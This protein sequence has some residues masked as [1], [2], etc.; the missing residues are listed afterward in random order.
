MLKSQS[1]RVNKA[2]KVTNKR[3]RKLQKQQRKNQRRQQRPLPFR[4]QTSLSSEIKVR[5]Y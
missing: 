3:N 2:I 4:S 5:M 1:T